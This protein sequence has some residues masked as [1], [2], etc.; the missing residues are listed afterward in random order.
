[1]KVVTGIE[2]WRNF[3]LTMFFGYT[4][5]YAYVVLQVCLVFQISKMFVFSFDL[6]K[7]DN[8]EAK[9]KK[10]N[11]KAHSDAEIRIKDKKAQ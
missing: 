11:A 3:V 7:Q 6:F 4:F 5:A 1:M 2:S 8:M 9:D 10:A